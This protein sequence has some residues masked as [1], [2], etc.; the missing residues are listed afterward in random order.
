M[1]F[2]SDL[3]EA[4]PRL[5]LH[6]NTLSK[7]ALLYDRSDFAASPTWT[8]KSAWTDAP[9]PAVN[10]QASLVGGGGAKIVRVP[11]FGVDEDNDDTASTTSRS[12]WVVSRASTTQTVKSPGAY[13]RLQSIAKPTPH[14]LSDLLNPPSPSH[15]LSMQNVLHS[16]ASLSRTG[17]NQNQKKKANQDSSFAFRQFVQD[18][19]AICGVADGHGPH[20]R[21]VARAL[22]RT[23][24]GLVA[25][26]LATRGEVAV[27]S[28][29]RA[30]F[31]NAHESLRGEVGINMRLSGSTLVVRWDVSSSCPLHPHP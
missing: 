25:K 9:R 7:S 31:L 10:E 27:Q 19:Q 30:A 5:V 22:S 18:H 1:D 28:V 3:E 8:L 6:N 2:V 21:S 15:C 14:P 12:T 4:L 17:R 11:D 29:F 26:E 16:M 23:I 13:L 24:P 20:G